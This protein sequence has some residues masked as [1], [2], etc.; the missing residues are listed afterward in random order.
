MA[1]DGIKKALFDGDNDKNNVEDNFYNLSNKQL[2]DEESKSGS[3][4][5][6]VEPRAYSESQQI[7]DYLKNRNTVVVNLKRVTSDQAK[8]LIDFLTGCIYAIGG[9]LQKLGNGIYLCTPNNV[10]IQGKMSENEEKEKAKT[11]FDSEIDF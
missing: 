6:L 3:K 5:I 1:F 10:N 4:M 8:R 2:K 9:N 7:A 11:K